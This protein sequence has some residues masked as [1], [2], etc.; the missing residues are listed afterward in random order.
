MAELEQGVAD[1]ML[2][3][4]APGSGTLMRETEAL[5]AGLDHLHQEPKATRIE[6]RIPEQFEKKLVRTLRERIGRHCA[7]DVV[8]ANDL[9]RMLGQ[10]T[11]RILQAHDGP[12]FVPQLSYLTDERA[13]R[14]LDMT[15]VPQAQYRGELPKPGFT[16][17]FASVR[18]YSML[19]VMGASMF[20]MASLMRSY[21][22]FTIPLTIL[23]VGFGTYSVITST[24]QQRAENTEREL[25]AARLAL[26][27]DVRRILADVQKAWPALVSDHLSQ[28]VSA[29]LAAVEA[30]VRDH[31]TRRGAEANPERERLQRRIAALEVADKRLLPVR[32]QRE[33]LQSTLDQVRAELR[34]LWPK[35]SVA[36]PPPAPASPPVAKAAAPAG[37]SPSATATPAPSA[38]A[39]APVEP[40]AAPPVDESKRAFAAVEQ[41]RA[42][43][44]ALK[45]DAAARKAAG[46]G[47]RG[48]GVSASEAAFRG[49]ERRSGMRVGIDLGTTYSLISDIGPEGRPRLI[50]DCL[51][52]ELVHTPSVIH[53]EKASAFVGSMAEA[54]LET[55]PSATVVRFF[56]R[57]LGTTR[58]AA[59]RR[60]GPRLAGGRSRGARAE[61]AR[62]RRRE[63]GLVAGGERG[64]HGA[65]ALQRPAAAR[66][67]GRGGAR[68][69]AGARPGGGAGRG[70]AA[71]R[72]RVREAGPHPARLRFRRRDIRRHRAEPRREGRLRAGQDRP[73]RARR[74]GDRRARGRG[75]AG[76][77]REG[78]GTRRPDGRPHA[79]GAAARL[80]GA[81][82]RAVP[83][84]AALGAPAGPARG[85]GG[86][87]RD[88]PRGLRRGDEGPARADR[89]RDAALRGRGGAA[90]RGRERRA[91][92]GR[93][94]VHPDGGGAAARDLLRPD[95]QLR[96]HEP[97]KAIAYGAALHAAQLA[98][99]AET[100][101]IPPEL[102]GVTG[103]NVGVR[104]VDAASGRVAVD[105][106]VKKNMPLPS[107]AARPTTPARK[108]QERI[109][110]DFVQFRE[111][112]ELV[113]LGPAHVGPLPPRV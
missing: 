94:L 105:T 71:L 30:A 31:F 27:P 86:R 89:G 50:P 91:D 76:A 113:P 64:D 96:H 17:Y 97:S 13:R 23:L 100:Y 108:N 6:T 28:Q 78:A 43:L 104:T 8:A 26:R 59:L 32:K 102:R 20:G 80:G 77:V 15:V 7:S 49:R 38:P 3:L 67:A 37:S 92:G 46:G 42:K 68:G 57:K 106:L 61:K 88:P 70:G 10:E 72:R 9:F 103:Y 47:P 109:V 55:D 34:N 5:L 84:D 65:G 73:H 87:G 99:D 107:K 18:K 21:K 53:I 24:A 1:R 11:E 95:Q 29:L 58:G 93:L 83:A 74:Q 33:A 101:Q 25:E 110:L 45:A 81:E 66:R 69:P 16:E 12:A 62:L 111:T 85:P 54:L 112:T 75:G 90:P 82:D 52:P 51:E 40:Q 35:P 2:D 22:E 39:E 48:R 14:L 36:A 63:P 19:L 60:A 4:V 56:K 79:A 44:A 98:G 41:A